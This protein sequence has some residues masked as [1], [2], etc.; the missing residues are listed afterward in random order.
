MKVILEPNAGD[1]LSNQID[2]ANELLEKDYVHE[3]QLQMNDG[4]RFMRTYHSG[5]EIRKFIWAGYNN[6]FSDVQ[7]EADE[8]EIIPFESKIVV[9]CDGDIV[10]TTSAYN[11]G[12]DLDPELLRMTVQ[13]TM[14][15]IE[16]G[17][18]F[19]KDVERWFIGWAEQH[20]VNFREDFDY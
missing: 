10:Y 16:C 12:S 8:L 1:S 20:I 18:A 13:E 17:G 15:E 4:L 7:Y 14:D 19:N 2:L 6:D 11:D 3:V 9:A 5:D